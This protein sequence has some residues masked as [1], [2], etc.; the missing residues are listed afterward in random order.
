MA[1]GRPVYTIHDIADRHGRLVHYE[2]LLLPFSRDGE[3]VDRIL[4]S[5]EFFCP[6][7]GFDT[8]DLLS[9][10]NGAPALRLSATIAPLAAQNRSGDNGIVLSGRYGD[11]V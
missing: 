7:G 6:D 5:F 11:N 9:A 4:A 3:S 2:R 1:T 8:S 10:Q